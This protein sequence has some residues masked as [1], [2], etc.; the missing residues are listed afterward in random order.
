MPLPTRG[1]VARIYDEIATD[2]DRLRRRPWPEVLEFAESLSSRTLIADL[3]CGSGRHA[4]V[5]VEGDHDVV[6][7]D[8]SPRLLSIARRKLPR[9]AFVLGDLCALPFRDAS[10]PALIAVAAIHH[11]PSESERVTAMREIARVLRPTGRALITAWSLDDSDIGTEHD[12]HSAGLGPG[13]VWV[14][15]R[16]GGKEVLRFYHLFAEGELP[17]LAGAAGL[18]VGKYF[19]SADNYVVVVG[20]RG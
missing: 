1:E 20:R 3:G 19:R 2:Y 18:H 12:A 14:P 17:R 7:L 6:G 8:A 10:F 4:K 15:W 13:D 5:L 11:L 16:A 9:A